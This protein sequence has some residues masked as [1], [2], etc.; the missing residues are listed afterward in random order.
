MKELYFIT[1][2]ETTGKTPV[3]GSLLTLG[4]VV[5]DR[6]EIAAPDAPP[7][8]EFYERLFYSFGEDGY[9]QDTLNWWEEQRAASPEG[10]QAYDEAFSM[11]KHRIPQRAAMERFSTFV[12]RELHAAAADVAIFV[13]K[14][15]AMDAMWVFGYFDKHRVSNPFSIHALD[16]RS[17][18]LGR[19]PQKQMTDLGTTE[20]SAAL[21]IDPAGHN[22]RAID[23]ARHLAQIVSKI[24]TPRIKGE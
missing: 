5:Y 20:I 24:M 15:V 1:D 10:A 13:S 7:S 9:D 19:E 4:S 11:I 22:H 16:V 2:V 6:E 14:P 23:D 8:A 21:G 18:L 3:R 12:K 17:F